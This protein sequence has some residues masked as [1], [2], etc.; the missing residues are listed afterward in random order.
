MSRNS[1]HE[2]SAPSVPY[3]HTRTNS[4]EFDGVGTQFPP[5]SQQTSWPRP[6]SIEIPQEEPTQSQSAAGD[7]APQLSDPPR[8]YAT[9]FRRARDGS[10]STITFVPPTLK[11]HMSEA[12]V[13]LI[14]AERDR[15]KLKEIQRGMFVHTILVN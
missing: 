3:T 7:L 11:H 14:I 15:L 9:T 10:R 6:E 5:P 4:R 13:A 1:S 8:N 12:D 2:R